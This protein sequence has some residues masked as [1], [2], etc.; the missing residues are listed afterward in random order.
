MT[1]FFLGL[2][3]GI[4]GILGNRNGITHSLEVIFYFT[5]ALYLGIAIG[6]EKNAR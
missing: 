4:V 1:G 6:Q 3:G 2:L 5:G